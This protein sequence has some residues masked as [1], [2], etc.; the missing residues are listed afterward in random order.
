M[1][2]PR[3]KVGMSD[4]ANYKMGQSESTPTIYELLRKVLSKNINLPTC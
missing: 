2:D 4:I 1:D 3:W